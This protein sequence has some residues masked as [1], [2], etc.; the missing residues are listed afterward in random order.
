[1]LFSFPSYFEGEKFEV[2]LGSSGGGLGAAV[3]QVGGPRKL[4][5]TGIGL[6]GDAGI[7]VGVVRSICGGRECGA[8]TTDPLMVS[9][10]EAARLGDAFTEQ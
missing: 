10:G 2:S 6:I 3:V 4:R 7:G 9:V 1:L 8:V 5:G